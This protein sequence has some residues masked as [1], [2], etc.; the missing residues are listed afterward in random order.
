MSTN[1]S[2]TKQR[3]ID[4]AIDL[5]WQNSYSSVSVNGICKEANIKKGSFYHFFPSKVDLAL[6]VIDQYF[7]YKRQLMDAM[8]SASIPPL[9]RFY[10]LID[11]IYNTQKETLEKYGKVCGCPLTILGSEMTGQEERIRS[12]VDFVFI[13]LQK[14]YETA[15][16]DLVGQG[17]LPPDTNV[18]AIVGHLNAYVLGQV[19]LARIYNSLETLEQEL[20]PRVMHILGLS[21][22]TSSLYQLVNL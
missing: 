1:I 15:I 14:Y 5:I 13:T 19:T 6:A 2:L 22:E 4:T 21:K 8:F 10:N 11:H 7:D 3:L 16:R 17:D 18:T 20:T 9:N 12:K